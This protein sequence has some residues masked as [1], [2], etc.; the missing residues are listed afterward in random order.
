MAAANGEDTTDDIAKRVPTGTVLPPRG[1]RDTIEKVAAY[2]ARNGKPFEDKLREKNAANTSYLDPEDE[3][4][5]YYEWRLA[6]NKAG[7]GLD[8]NKSLTRKTDVGFE[9]KAVYVPPQPTEFQFSARMPTISAQ[10]LEIV[11]LTALF[12][13]KNGRSWITGL[14]QK[15]AGNYQFDFLR[16]QHSLNMYFNR[17]MEQ[18][19]DLLDGETENDGA[20]QKKR[21][22]EL[23][24]NITN[25]F[26]VL[27][28]AKQRAEYHKYLEKQKVDKEEKAEADRI[29]FAQIDW[30]DFL[31]VATVTFDENDE[32]AEMPP[33]KT[34]NDMM[35]LS[36]EQK[37]NMTIDA[38]R[39]L[40][41][42][43]PS[44][45][46]YN[47][48]YGQQPQY[49]AAQVITPYPP[50]S[51]S[52][53]QASPYS[54]PTE[55]PSLAV[56]REQARAAA[57]RANQQARV[58]TD[59]V[60]QAQRR[61]QQQNTSICSICKQAIPNEEMEQHMRIEMLSPEWRE[62][63]AKNQQRSSTTNL[64][65]ADVANNLKRLASQRADLFDSVTGNPITEEEAARRKR[66]EQGAYDGVSQIPNAAALGAM[67][68]Q[69]GG[70]YPPGTERPNV[71][72]QIRYI[73]DKYKK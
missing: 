60:P 38:N 26:H 17:L 25:R 36:L 13:A 31:V 16:P 65:T 29:A 63:M 1:V 62:Q 15:E 49:P 70:T 18:Y 33:P 64:S 28:S 8:T 53:P 52:P 54:L 72:D 61:N 3:Y 50:P 9:G 6:E 20:S 27:D 23:E 69:P 59:Y 56:E 30:H 51:A 57:K 48:F 43:M 14:S 7:R 5:P 35:S 67:G 32:T 39:R 55:T 24:K 66:A 40:E 47:E 37:A 22:A 10:D 45:D 11:K 44:L 42:A 12:A 71:E 19:K 34:L 68:Q 58:R 73:H 4:Y 41:E 21:M 46:D 2:V